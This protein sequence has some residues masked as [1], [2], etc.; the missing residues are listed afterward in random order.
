MLIISFQFLPYLGSKNNFSY[1]NFVAPPVI[2]FSLIGILYKKILTLQICGNSYN[3]SCK[4]RKQKRKESVTVQSSCIRNPIASVNENIIWQESFVDYSKFC[5][6][7]KINRPCELL[8]RLYVG[9]AKSQ[10]SQTSTKI[11]GYSV[12]NI[13]IPLGGRT[14]G[15]TGFTGRRRSKK[16]TMQRSNH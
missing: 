6:F 4:N 15:G 5:E 1:F 12:P 3:S 16:K 10:L 13:V 8:F 9:Y 11:S 2:I 14:M 7:L